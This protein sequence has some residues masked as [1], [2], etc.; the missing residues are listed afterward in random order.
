MNLSNSLPFFTLLIVFFAANPVGAQNSITYKKGQ[1]E[2][3][4]SYTSRPILQIVNEEPIVHDLRHGAEPAPNYIIPLTP[5]PGA[6]SASTKMLQVSPSRLSAAGFQT[7]IGAR[8][9]VRALNQVK[10]G[11]LSPVDK[12]R[13]IGAGKPQTASQNV[14]TGPSAAT[15]KSSPA[16]AVYSRNNYP[17]S[18]PSGQAGSQSGFSKEV[19]AR[20]RNG[21]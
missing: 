8:Q 2:Q 5:L 17:A 14:F 6:T 13:P 21:K 20:L 9:P 11:G 1:L 18:L 10:M 3:V 7:N 19:L 16:V 12:V 4:K 15:M